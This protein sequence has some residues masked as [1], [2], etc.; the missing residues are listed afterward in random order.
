MFDEIAT[1]E[2]LAFTAKKN[3]P[4]NHMTTEDV[5]VPICKLCGR[6]R[7]LIDAH[8]IPRAFYPPRSP[9]GEA[10]IVPGFEGGY[11]RR[12]PIGVYDQRILCAECDGK[13]G[14][15]DQHVVEHV[16]RGRHNTGHFGMSREYVD[17]EPETVLKFAASVAWRA[18][19]SSHD[20]FKTMKLGPYTDKLHD[21]L[22]A[23]SAEPP[24]AGWIAEFESNEVPFLNPHL[25]R[26]SGVNAAVIY[27]GRLVF[28]LKLDKRP[29]PSDFASFDLRK[30]RPV[31]SVVREFKNG[32]EIGLM[33]RMMAQP[34]MQGVRS[35][36]ARQ[37]AKTPAK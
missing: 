28:Y 15:L 22:T 31:Y 29:V 26:F 20:M 24:V 6:D 3:S 2:C 4:H 13:L 30:G 36:W 23:K 11:P 25:T 32:K 10:V 7:P 5:D 9:V 21:W 35:R 34:S 18:A 33:Q 1:V 19:V 14:Q 16:L 37:R 17:A 8:V 12:T 27:A